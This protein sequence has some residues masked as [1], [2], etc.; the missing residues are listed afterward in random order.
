MLEIVCGVCLGTEINFFLYFIFYVNYINLYISDLYHERLW[1]VCV[2]LVDGGEGKDLQSV[3]D[4]DNSR[5][6]NDYIIDHENV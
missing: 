2:W 3:H 1:L 5:Q 4:I 6:M